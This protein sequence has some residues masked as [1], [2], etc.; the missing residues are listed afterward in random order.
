MLRT[1]DG[2]TTVHSVPGFAH[3]DHH[4]LWI[5]PVE[6]RR[7][8]AG[9][10]GGV[11]LSI[12]GGKSWRAPALPLAQFYNVD[13][14]DRLPYHVGGTIQDQ[15]TASAPSNSLKAGGHALAEWRPAG[16]GE[17]GDFVYD[18]G[19]P[20]QVYAG[21]YGGYLSH[22]D[23]STG[24]TRMVT[25]YPTNPSGH[26]AEDLR[27][28]FQWTAPLATSAHDPAVLYHG[29]RGALPHRR[30]RRHVDG[31]LARSDAQRPDQDA[32]VGR[33]DH[34]RQHRRRDLRHDLLDRR[35]AARCR[36]DLGGHR[37]RAGPVDA[38]RRRDLGATSRRRGC[39]LG[40]P[41]SASSPRASRRAQPTSWSMPT[42]ST[43]IAPT[44]SA[45]VIGA[46]LGRVSRRPCRRT[47]I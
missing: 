39:R 28:R 5:D 21:E 40:R 42:G 43:T 17:A 31:D 23:Q 15:G 46:R 12:D 32:L 22:H 8:I 25:I 18:E 3:G 10:D 35:V 33:P 47:R 19:R 16:G 24:R 11:D 14:D 7:M 20:G 6:P 38:R 26:G 9:N 1:I 41:S 4:D 29:A 37:R 45:R 36:R 34:R 30:P 2:G 27:H 13:V 44:C